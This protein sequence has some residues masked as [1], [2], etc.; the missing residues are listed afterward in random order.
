MVL[1]MRH[2]YYNYGYNRINKMK[3]FPGVDYIYKTIVAVLD[4]LEFIPNLTEKF[5]VNSLPLRIFYPLNFDRNRLF[6]KQLPL[7]VTKTTVLT[8]LK[9]KMCSFG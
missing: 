3:S 8:G 1:Q 4:N 6:V 7:H 2:S 9:V 5:G